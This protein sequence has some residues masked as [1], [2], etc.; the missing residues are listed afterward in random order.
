[1]MASLF[2]LFLL[3]TVLIAIGRYSAALVLGLINLVFALIIF[4]SHLTATIN[5]EL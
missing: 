1:M 2:L 4:Y 3:V 5:I